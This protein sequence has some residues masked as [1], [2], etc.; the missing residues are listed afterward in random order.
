MF[1]DLDYKLT[2]AEFLAKIVQNFAEVHSELIRARVI[3]DG[4]YEYTTDDVDSSDTDE[5]FR[6]QLDSF[7]ESLILL[8]RPAEEI[9]AHACEILSRI[10]LL[11]SIQKVDHRMRHRHSRGMRHTVTIIA[12][13]KTADADKADPVCIGWCGCC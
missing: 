13:P 3:R 9:I 7:F 4:K 2:D 11:W 10:G 6:H 8:Q 1:A 12:Y 5:S